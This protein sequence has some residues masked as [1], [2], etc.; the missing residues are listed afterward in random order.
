[1]DFPG[2]PVSSQIPGY[3]AKDFSRLPGKTVPMVLTGR[4]I[5]VSAGLGFLP[6]YPASLI[7][8]LDLC[9]LDSPP[10]LVSVL[11]AS[12]LATGL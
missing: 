9:A 10:K 2:Y 3:P 8:R 1:M 4:Q 7:S 6:G 12:F 11:V 5:L